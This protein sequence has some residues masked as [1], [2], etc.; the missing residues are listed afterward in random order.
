M[1]V[2]DVLSDLASLRACDQAEALALVNI[3]NAEQAHG[4]SQNKDVQRA[5]ELIELH[6]SMKEHHIYQN[7]G[8]DAALH[9]ARMDVDAVLAKLGRS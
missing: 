5:T 7:G 6:R 4:R 3:H 1:Q 2:A 9:Q 8:V